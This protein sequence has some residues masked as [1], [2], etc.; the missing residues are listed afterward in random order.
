MALRAKLP[1]I[2]QSPL[3]RQIFGLGALI[4]LGLA[5]AA[6]AWLDAGAQ[7]YS[8]PV[9][10]S[11]HAA[12][13]RAQAEH[14][15]FLRGAE[16]GIPPLARTR[17][18][19]EMDALPE[20]VG[21]GAW[22]DL[23][24]FSIT[25]GQGFSPP[26]TCNSPSRIRVSGRV[27][28]LAFGAD[29]STIYVGSAGGGVWKSTNS[30]LTWDPLT[31]QQA[32]LAVGALAVVPGPPD[33]IY[34]G[35]GEGNNGCD[36]EFGQGILK[37]VDGGA[38]WQQLP[39]DP[40]ERARTFDRLTFSK[41][42]VSTDNPQVLFAATTF[43]FTNGAAAECYSGPA[44][45]PQSGVYRSTNGGQNWVPLSDGTH[46]LPM[47]STVSSING[48]AFDVFI[49]PAKTLAGP[50]VGMVTDMGGDGCP[51]QAVLA[52]VNPNDAADPNPFK[53]YA[54]PV[55]GGG[56]NLFATLRLAQNPPAKVDPALPG[57]CEDYS[58]D[59]TCTGSVANLN[60][61]PT[62]NLQCFGG[63]NGVTINLNGSF[64]NGT[65]P[66]GTF[67][68]TWSM[69]AGGGPDV[70]NAPLTLNAASAV[71]AG[72]A[73][74]AA[75][76]AAGGLYRS[77]NGGDNWSRVNQDPALAA[78]PSSFYR[79]ALDSAPDGSFQ[80]IMPPSFAIARCHPLNR[81]R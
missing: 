80:P 73:G 51:G 58:G 28:A 53:L 81:R 48:S 69:N 44:I 30:G 13:L 47:G 42:I 37:S 15:T 27:T 75:G 57:I 18:I 52:A 35:T 71:Y 24:P 78:A 16:R 19:A 79:F 72:I 5:V 40:L 41:I 21:I 11:D 3:T 20:A 64:A 66:T 55:N 43:G 70:V 12:V 67:N 10:L 38:T 7:N 62:S 25:S 77:T 50:F 17:A 32:S 54:E 36:N 63:A 65:T 60:G 59:Y 31:D 6:A 2:F 33:T 46:G 49:D 4:A 34:V 68:G 1:G 61:A 22:S 9:G 14:E 39:A 56:Y 76:A 8:R 26:G 29:P 45:V 74:P 23:G